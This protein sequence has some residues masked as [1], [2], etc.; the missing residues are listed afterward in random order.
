MLLTHELTGSSWGL[1]VLGQPSGSQG[2][3]AAPPG[4]WAQ[5]TA[6]TGSLQTLPAWAPQQQHSRVS[7]LTRA[8]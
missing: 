2:S 8:P 7:F 4:L 5:T 1:C 3:G 6:V